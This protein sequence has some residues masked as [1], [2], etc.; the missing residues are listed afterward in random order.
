M[1]GVCR[2]PENQWFMWF[3]P[4]PWET[5]EIIVS[6][7]NPKGDVTIKDMELAALLAQIYI[8]AP[9]IQPLAQ[10]FTAVDNMEAQGWP[11]RGS[12]RSTMAV[13]T[14]LRD[15]TFLTWGQ[16]IYASVSNI[17]GAYNT[18][19]NAASRLTH[20]T[21]Q[22]LLRHFSL[23]FLQENPWRLFPLPSNCRQRLTSML[24]SKRYHMYFQPP[25]NRRTPP[26]G[27]NGE[28]SMFGC[29]SQPTSKV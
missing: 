12:I 18:M 23:T 7:S 9:K 21:N 1:V 5:Q 4:F 25:S 2:D 13:G 11:N 29:T 10:I 17:K 3:S 14:I 8:F 19:A 28:N 6:N 22:M 26:H 16:H 20:L 27:A 15:L 24:H